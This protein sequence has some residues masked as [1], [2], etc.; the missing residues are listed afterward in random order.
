MIAG[1]ELVLDGLRGVAALAQGW[2]VAVGQPYAKN[3]IRVALIGLTVAI[4]IIGAL[5]LWYGIAYMG[6]AE[7]IDYDLGYYVKITARL[8]SSGE[9]YS[10][11]QLAG[12]WAVNFTDEVMYPPA[13]VWFFAPFI[14]L[15][16]GVLIGLTVAVLAWLFRQWRPAVWTWPLLAFCLAWPMT[17]LRIMTGSSD[18]L[19]VLAVGLGLQY[20][21]AAAFALLKPSFLPFA[22]IGIRSRGWWIAAGI[23]VLLSLPWLSETLAYPGVMLNARSALGP[24]YSLVGLQ[25]VLIP[26]IAWAGRTAR[27]T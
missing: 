12:P 19:V 17:T 4:L 7:A 8:F 2:A 23:M 25:L 1:R 11:R 21:G 5:E 9:W 14:I 10:A 27:R 22:L 20:R 16:V 24:F 13:I 26:V 3:L 15:P 6:W 18:L